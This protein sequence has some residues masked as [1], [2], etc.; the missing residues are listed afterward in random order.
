M[1]ARWGLIA[2]LAA[3]QPRPALQDV[4]GQ[5]FGAAW[6]VRWVGALGSREVE[7]AAT[8][9]F[10]E[11]DAATSSWRADSELSRARAGGRVAAG[12]ALRDVLGEALAVAA[13][14]GGAF[15]PTV[16]PLVEL[17]T[18]HGARRT[19]RPT[20][21][22]VADARARVDWRRVSLTGEGL[23]LDGAALDLSAI[24]PGYAADRVSDALVALG[25][26][27]SLVDVGGEVRARGRA[28]DGRWRVALDRPVDGSA[29]AFT[30]V[31]VSD[32]AVATSGHYR[33]HY[34]VEGVAVGNAIDP[35]TGWPS[36]ADVLSATVFAPRASTADAWATALMV[37]GEDGLRVL[38][39][40]VDALM[41]V[42]RRIVTTPGV[43]RYWTAT[44]L[45][46]E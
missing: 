26:T 36:T 18:L 42:G 1:P 11:V 28:P 7:M 45:P 39:D 34:V 27:D 31:A 19:T 32:A 40:G 30:V 3:C 9:V 15:D 4:S 43:G 14:S 2:M 16:Q 25:V 33:N 38:P 46:V 21:L 5:T 13:A 6:S 37:L 10:A 24:A 23:D 35:R 22:E 8:Q 44:G 12:P 29:G 17:W 41:V 20:D